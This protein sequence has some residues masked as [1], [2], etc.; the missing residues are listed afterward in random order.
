[1]LVSVLPVAEAFECFEIATLRDGTDN[2]KDEYE[3]HFQHIKVLMAD[4]IHAMNSIRRRVK[5]DHDA[6][7]N[8]WLDLQSVDASQ[9]RDNAAKKM[10]RASET[11]N[12][13]H[14]RQRPATVAVVDA[15]NEGLA[16]ELDVEAI[17]NESG[18][19]E[20]YGI[21][22]NDVDAANIIFNKF[23]DTLK[24]C[25]GNYYFKRENV[26]VNSKQIVEDHLLNF[27]LKS[28]KFEKLNAKGKRL[29]YSRN[30]SGAH[31]IREAVLVRVRVDGKTRNY[32]KNLLALLRAAFVF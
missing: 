25:G 6:I 11:Q 32:I 9:W 22:D 15:D 23:K 17:D 31:A 30:V 5:E 19:E 2:K 3:D 24:F 10:R 27:I 28:T 29:S 13:E 7:F 18:G 12:M 14:K 1:M 20:L 26:W 21:I 4:Q 16:K 8:T